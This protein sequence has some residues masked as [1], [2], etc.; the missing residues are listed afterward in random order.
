[1]NPQ[2]MKAMPSSGSRGGKVNLLPWICRNSKWLGHEEPG[3]LPVPMI[4]R[5]RWLIH[6]WSAGGETRVNGYVGDNGLE[7]PALFARLVRAPIEL[8]PASSEERTILKS[9]SSHMVACAGMSSP[10]QMSF[11]LDAP[12]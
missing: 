3:D 11:G 9:T 12:P 1:M 7:I 2:T 4:D 10:S 5:A 8:A 6:L